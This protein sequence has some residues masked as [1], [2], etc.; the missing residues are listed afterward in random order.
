[1]WFAW[2]ILA[3]LQVVSKRYMKHYWRYSNLI[4]YIL[5]ATSGILTLASTII[6]LDWLGWAFYLDHWHNVAGILFMVLC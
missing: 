3:L 2:T 5:G 1:M 4:H 6:V